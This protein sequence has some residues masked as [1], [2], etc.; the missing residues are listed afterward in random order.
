ME[1]DFEEWGGWL[2]EYF[3]S[4]DI[5]EIE[6][7]EVPDVWYTEDI[8]EIEDPLLR[9]KEI[10][11]AEK[12]VDQEQSL[13]E[14]LEAG[15]ITD[16]QYLAEYEYGIRPKKSKLATRTAFESVGLTYDHLGDLSEDW[17]MLTAGDLNM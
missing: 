5:E 2:E 4:P 8:H 7:M 16:D 9:A 15:E 12:I 6:N 11:E 3:E 10:M 13:E 1:K 17:E 14:Q